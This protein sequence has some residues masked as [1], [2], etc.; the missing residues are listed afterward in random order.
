MRKNGR[1]NSFMTKSLQENE[2]DVRVKKFLN[3]AAASLYIEPVN[4]TEEW[5]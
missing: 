2:P 1:R 5:K 3:E 4:H